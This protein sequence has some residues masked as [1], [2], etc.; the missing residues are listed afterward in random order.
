MILPKPIYKYQS[1]EYLG[2]WLFSVPNQEKKKFFCA[3]LISYGSKLLRLQKL[4]YIC[5]SS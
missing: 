1:K 2:K 3:A 5:L 4:F